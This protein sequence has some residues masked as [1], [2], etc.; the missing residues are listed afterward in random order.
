MIEPSPPV[1]LAIGGS[2]SAGMA[3]IQM[4]ARVIH[5]LGGHAAT[6]IT[7]TTAQ[8]SYA[9]DG[10]HPVSADALAGQL[11]ACMALSP[12]AVKIGML[13][14]PVQVDVCAQVLAHRAVPMVI[15]PVMVSS[16]G[17]T[18][19]DDRTR[20]AIRRTLL[21]LCTVVTPNL[22]EAEAWLKQPLGGPE[23]IERAATDICRSARCAVVIKGGHG[24]SHLSSDH[25]RHPT[26]TQSPNRYWLNARRLPARHRRGTGCAFA[27]ATAT[28]LALGY[29]LDDA[30]VIARMAIHQGLR[31]GYGVA[32]D[33]GPANI[34]HF[35][36]N[37][38]SLPG[39]HC[40]AQEAGP[41]FADCGPTPLGLYPIVDRARW[42]ATLLPLG[43]TTVQLRIKDLT[44]DALAAELKAGTDLARRHGARLF[45]NDH[46]RLAID[47]GAYGV[48]LGQEDLDSADLEALR[49]ANLRLG[50]STHCH[51]EVA[52]AHH[53]RPSYMAFGPVYATATKDM[54]WIPRGP[55]GFRYWRNVLR[56]YPL[57]AI[58]G[59]NAARLPAVAAAG[60]D[61]IALISAITGAPDPVTE[62]Q[63]LLQAFNRATPSTETGYASAK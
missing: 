20:E 13:A 15:D 22:P 2:D 34:R 51:H 57:V 6:A 40:R 21:P 62:T 32:G 44:G 8:H 12:A 63:G 27:C 43:I 28:G 60:A 10:L 47:L 48:H 53:L 5:A 61:G 52:R 9:V 33:S 25:V 35:P 45:I 38:E 54:P 31:H 36:S 30:L 16:S 41:P 26:E 17:H 50:I 42:L 7:A 23:D 46:W 56:G 37:S 39:L 1:V 24:A 14:N 19:V 58:G 29:P 18:L 55:A 49:A 4:D 11:K 3:G 59:I